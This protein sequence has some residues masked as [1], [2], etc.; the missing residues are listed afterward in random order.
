MT[1]DTAI[2]DWHLIDS[3]SDYQTAAQIMTT[4]AQSVIAQKADEAI[5]VTEH[6]PVYTAGTSSKDSD[7]INPS[8]FD[9]VKT[10]R[11][12]QWTYHGPG[13][14][15]IWPVLNLNNRQQDV[16]AYIRHLEGWMSDTLACFG[17]EAKTREGLPGLWVKRTDRHQAEQMDKIVAIGVRISR[18][19]TMHGVAL[20]IDP[21]LS[22]FEGIVP[23]GVTDGGVTSLAD[24]GYL[25]SRTEIEMAAKSCFIKWFG[26]ESQMASTQS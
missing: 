21:D 3:P 12:G 4:H 24:L 22:H 26:P 16:R 6:K 7:L 13:Q 5:F 19:V 25:V 1:T 8:G 20:N 11:G 18:W 10:G 14:L 2:P 9:I 15:V 23:C 17:I